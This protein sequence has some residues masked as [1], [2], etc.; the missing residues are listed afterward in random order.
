MDL[1]GGGCKV[2]LGIDDNAPV[3]SLPAGVTPGSVVVLLVKNA[4]HIFHVDDESVARCG[5]VC[6][7]P[8]HTNEK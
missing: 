6:A 4:Q 7:Y 5:Y 2:L 3:F 1:I 8:H